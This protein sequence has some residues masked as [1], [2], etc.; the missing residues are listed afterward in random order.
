MKLKE[1]TAMLDKYP[2]IKERPREMF[3]LMEG[4]NRGEFSTVDA[5]NFQHFGLMIANAHILEYPYFIGSVVLSF[6]TVFL[7]IHGKDYFSNGGSVHPIL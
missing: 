1:L 6:L 5:K 7:A 3:D 2:T 4:P